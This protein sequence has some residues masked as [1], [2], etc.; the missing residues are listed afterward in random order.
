[1]P[2]TAIG[3]D[4]LSRRGDDDPPELRERRPGRLEV[5]RLEVDQG[6][7]ER[8]DDEVAADD[9]AARLVPQRDL[10][11]DRRVLV[12]PASIWAGPKIVVSA[13]KR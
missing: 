1:M 11:A 5:D 8:D 7:V 6:V 2:R 9:V 4:D 3:P 13:G 10:G 12:D